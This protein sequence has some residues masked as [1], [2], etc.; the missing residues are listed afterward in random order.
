[1]VKVNSYRYAILKL[2]AMDNEGN[3]EGRPASLQDA[4]WDDHGWPADVRPS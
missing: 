3:D 2:L 1:M 4:L